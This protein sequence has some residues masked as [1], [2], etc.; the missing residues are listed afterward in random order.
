MDAAVLSAADLQLS[1]VLMKPAVHVALLPELM[2][3]CLF[4]DVLGVFG[5]KTKSPQQD[6]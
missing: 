1:E 6:R 2:E 3:S 4:K 5:T